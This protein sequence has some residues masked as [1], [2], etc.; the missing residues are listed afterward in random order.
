ME[1]LPKTVLMSK[2][3]GW[4]TLW[5]TNESFKMYV[6]ST[7]SWCANW[8][9]RP[10]SFFFAY[11]SLIKSHKAWTW[12]LATF[13]IQFQIEIFDK[14]PYH[15]VWRI[16]TCMIYNGESKLFVTIMSFESRINACF[17]TPTCDLFNLHRRIFPI[18]PFYTGCTEH[19]VSHNTMIYFSRKIPLPLEW[20]LLVRG[21]K[22]PSLLVSCSESTAPFKK[23]SRPNTHPLVP[24]SRQHN[25]NYTY[26]WH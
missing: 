12:Y 15:L 5:G 13:H 2:S 25:R 18:F 4:I 3:N 26:R 23:S 19:N 21:C 6:F 22:L 9:D 11:L 17:I 24:S 7:K 1:N 20:R 14:I 16:V 8:R 10:T